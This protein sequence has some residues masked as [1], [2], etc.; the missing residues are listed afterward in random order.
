MKRTWST[1]LAV[2]VMVS[3][4]LAGCARLPSDVDS[5]TPSPTQSQS[6]LPSVTPSVSPSGY[7]T[8]HKVDMSVKQGLFYEIFV[9]SFADSNGDGIGDL[10]GVTAKLDYLKNLGV[11]GIW[12]T[13]IH[14]SPSYHGYDVVDYD[15][16]NPDFGT[17]ADFLNL[18]T[19]AHQRG[20]K[21]II[22][23]VANH[24]SSE[25]PWFLEAK[26]NPNSPYRDYYRF[27]SGDDP[28]VNLEMVAPWG[29]KVWRPVG[30]GTY[31]YGI[32]DSSMP[33]L[34]YDNPSVRQ[35]MTQ[36]AQKW[37]QRG[38]DGFRVDAAIHVYAGNEPS[39]SGQD[40]T[41]K[42]L[43]WWNEFAL[44]CE[45]VNPQAYIVG[46]TW[47]T[48]Q[49]LAEYAQ[50]FDT[51]FDFPF[52]E[53]LA[54]AI[55]MGE[56]MVSQQ[57]LAEFF[58]NDLRQRLEADPK[59]LNGP[60]GSNH[61]L[62][63]MM[64][65]LTPV[66]S[67]DAAKL[68]ASIYLTLP[69]NPYIYYGEELGMYGPKPDE[70]IRE[71]FRWS[72]DGTGMDTTWQEDK[73]NNGVAPLSEQVNDPGSMYSH[74]ARLISARQDHAKLFAEGTFTAVPTDP[75]VMGYLRATSDQGIYVFH[76]FSI[77]TVTVD[78]SSLKLGSVVFTSSNSNLIQQGR[79]TLA[80]HGSVFVM[81]Q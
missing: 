35:A 36:A 17:M 79:I 61:D 26:A 27:V 34:N 41:T 13:P 73:V 31:Y 10:N 55:I 38:V 74:Y 57:P 65:A 1:A 49:V 44:A 72:G 60:F 32:F 28:G 33:D 15:A 67:P 37:M 68:V 64:S 71:P 80:P 81:K 52:Q 69:G 4:A 39:S 77:H 16:I 63:R 40:A 51:T 47:N 2:V 54:P 45:S 19:Q 75:A 20:I 3:V 42:N 21:V 9:R 11:Q 58:A 76:N 53:K 56:A 22:D 5:G 66:G 30:D 48:G 8:R 7:P 59:Y 46:E 62:P 12:L 29:G 78:V 50:P 14:P 6:Q 43:Q 70:V 23:F 25:H 24:T 18:L